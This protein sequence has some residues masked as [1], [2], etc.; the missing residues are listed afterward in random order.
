MIFV[1]YL[2][3]SDG[4]FRTIFLGQ[5]EPFKVLLGFRKM[6]RTIIQIDLIQ[7]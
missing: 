2:E 7:F 4:L 5:N 3:I 1:I 6:N